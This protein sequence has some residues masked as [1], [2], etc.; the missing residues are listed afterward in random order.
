MMRKLEHSSDKLRAAQLNK[1][2]NLYSLLTNPQKRYVSF[3]INIGFSPTLVLQV[4]IKAILFQAE[5]G[6]P[7]K[8]RRCVE[9][10]TRKAKGKESIGKIASHVVEAAS[11]PFAISFG[12]PS[13]L[14]LRYLASSPS[15]DS[16]CDKNHS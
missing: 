11:L 2:K 16:K 12:E 5:I 14:M 15:L 7:R 10:V 6:D 3:L 9:Q 4:F 1:M 8:V 13:M